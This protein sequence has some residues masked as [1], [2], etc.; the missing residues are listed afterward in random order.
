MYIYIIICKHANNALSP[1]YH[2]I[3]LQM[4]Y[5]V[6]RRSITYNFSEVLLH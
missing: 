1:C 2:K 4:T 3:D 5:D 6:C